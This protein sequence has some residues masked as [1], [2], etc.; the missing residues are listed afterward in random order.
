MFLHNN[1][2]YEFVKQ[3]LYQG[4]KEIKIETQTPNFLWTGPKIQ[5]RQWL[6]ATA[7]LKNSFDTYQAETVLQLGF[8]PAATADTAWIIYALPQEISKNALT[9]SEIESEERNKIQQRIRKKGFFPF[10]TMHHHCKAAAFH[11]QT[12]VEDEA[13]RPGLHV[14]LGD[15]H[16][17]FFSLDAEAGEA[18]I[19]CTST[20]ILDWVAVPKLSLEQSAVTAGLDA[21]KVSEYISYLQTR[22]LCVPGN[23]YPK[24]WDACLIEKLDVGV[25][26]SGWPPTDDYYGTTPGVTKYKI[27]QARLAK[28][29]QT[30]INSCS[31]AY[32]ISQ[33]DA[34]LG[35][36][37]CSE[38]GIHIP[39]GQND[40]VCELC[41]ARLCESC[42]DSWDWY[43]KIGNPYCDTCTKSAYP[44]V[45]DSL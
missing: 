30:T 2:I 32:A 9:V 5:Y 38:C 8:N 13:Q 40:P 39:T 28:E 11:S 41:G 43:D 24:E 18:G 19:L 17:T 23:T 4:A 36:D 7:F 45:A 37:N 10:G 44:E 3:D 26:Y 31:N 21:K 25:G 29:K 16:H 42:A 12:D 20:N 35:I 22:L 27:A 33:A 15:M 34:T 6:Q 1:K 14:T